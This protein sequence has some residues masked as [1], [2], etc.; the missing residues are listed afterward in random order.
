MTQRQIQKRKKILKTILPELKKLFPQVQTQLVAHNPFHLLV[1]VILSAQ[2]TDKQVNKVTRILFQK[3]PTLN[4]Y[5]K[6]D[7]KIFEQDIKPTGFYHN[8][9]K[10][11]LGAAKV[12]HSHFGGK[13]PKTLEDMITLPG[14]GRKTAHVVLGNLYGVVEGIAVDTHVR[15]LSKKFGL[16]DHTDP[17]KIEQD[18]IKLLPKK[19]WYELTYRFIEFGRNYCS[20]RKHDHDLCLKMVRLG[21]P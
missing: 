5:L 3:Y 2:C 21:T 15:R 4:D 11:I 6:A 13:I 12:I 16:T 14:V 1:A 18:L 19:E 20:A 7:I 8:K 17:N 9:A 10:N